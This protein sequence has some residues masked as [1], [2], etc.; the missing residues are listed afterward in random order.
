MGNDPH[1]TGLRTRTPCV[2]AR[3]AAPGAQRAGLVPALTGK[4]AGAP[5]ARF[6]RSPPRWPPTQPLV[7]CQSSGEVGVRVPRCGGR[8]ALDWV[9]VLP[10]LGCVPGASHLTPLGLSFL[11]E[12]H[13]GRPTGQGAPWEHCA[14]RGHKAHT[15][16]ACLRRPPSALCSDQA[17]REWPGATPESRGHRLTTGR[18]P[19]GG[20][21][22]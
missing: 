16:C 17:T 4:G 18:V 5:G 6:P 22:V 14:N 1:L 9:P 12:T 8:T 20:A 3:T 2:S 13:D 15:G 7:H 19:T 10:L 11:S 21:S